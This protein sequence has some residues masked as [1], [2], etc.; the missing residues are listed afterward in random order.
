MRSGLHVR[1]NVERILIGHLTMSLSLML[2]PNPWGYIKSLPATYF[3]L[4]VLRSVRFRQGFE[5]TP[6]SLLTPVD[7]CDRD[8]R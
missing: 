6:R 4:C 3:F 7:V 8:S 2:N 1:L 5:F